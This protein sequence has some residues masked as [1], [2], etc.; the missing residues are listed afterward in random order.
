VEGTHY[1]EIGEKER[2]PALDGFQPEIKL[3][4]NHKINLEFFN[5]LIRIFIKPPILIAS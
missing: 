5:F 4:I 2:N 3:F 1:L